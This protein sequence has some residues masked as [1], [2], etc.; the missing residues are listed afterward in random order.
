MDDSITLEKEKNYEL[1]LSV[2]ESEINALRELI[3]FNTN[4]TKDD[5]FLSSKRFQDIDEYDSSK[6]NENRHEHSLEAITEGLKE[7][8]DKTLQ[9][10]IVG[11]LVDEIRKMLKA[12]PKQ[13]NNYRRQLLLMFHEALKQNYTKKIFNEPQV[14][15]LAEIARSCNETFV[16]REQYLKMDDLLCACDLDMIPDME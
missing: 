8:G 1:R 16:T 15:A 10:P 13:K 9:V 14:R 6:T 2:V 12:I 4:L 7:S 5:Q 3:H 11:K